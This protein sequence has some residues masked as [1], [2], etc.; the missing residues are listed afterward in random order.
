MEKSKRDEDFSQNLGVNSSTMN[1]N[2]RGQSKQS[3]AVGAYRRGGDPLNMPSE[4]N[5][6]QSFSIDRNS[7]L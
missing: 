5:I 3:H 1:A 2:V 4:G 7:N 6:R